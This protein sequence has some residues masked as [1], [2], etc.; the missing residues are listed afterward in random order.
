MP[1]NF[2]DNE[3]SGEEEE[4]KRRKALTEVKIFSLAMIEAHRRGDVFREVPPK[5]L[6]ARIARHKG[7]WK[8]MRFFYPLQINGGICRECGLCMRL[9][10]VGNLTGP[11]IPRSSGEC[12]L[13]MRCVNVCPVGALG[14]KGIKR[15]YAAVNLVKMAGAAAQSP[16]KKSLDPAE[17]D[18][19]QADE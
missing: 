6:I 12:Q 5:K 9:C 19:T 16:P 14:V 2:F 17:A 15:R 10:P 7:T 3:K 11:G 4:E 8:M 18:R 1:N 13:C